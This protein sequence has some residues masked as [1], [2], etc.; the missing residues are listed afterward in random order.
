MSVESHWR[1]FFL[2]PGLPEAGVEK[3]DYY[4]QKFGAAR[5]QGLEANMKQVFASEGL[6]FVLGGKTGP[7]MNSQRLIAYAGTFGAEKQ[8]ALVEELMRNYFSEEKFLNDPDVLI[9]AAKKVGLPEAEKIVKD[10][11]AYRDQVMQE[12]QTYAQ[13]ISGVPH[14]LISSGSKTIELS[15]AQDPD[16]IAN[17]INQVIA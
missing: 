6:D 3:K 1:P 2:N 10:P 7:T 5:A 9:N 13:G 15:G 17:A 12:Y 8:H 4:R 16:T 14:F 11:T